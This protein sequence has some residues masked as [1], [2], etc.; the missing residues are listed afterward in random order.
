M[1]YLGI[2]LRHVQDL[3]GKSYAI[4]RGSQ[5]RCKSMETSTAFTDRKAEH[6][7]GGRRL[8]HSRTG[9]LNT[10]EGPATPN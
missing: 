5:R 6:G 1:K 2:Y 4:D 9:R 8:P 7:R 3:C 10:V